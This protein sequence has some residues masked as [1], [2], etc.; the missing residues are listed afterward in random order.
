M[1]EAGLGTSGGRSTIGRREPLDPGLRGAVLH[2]GL[3]A[4]ENPTEGAG[5]GCHR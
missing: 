3:T 1:K 4:T 2:A 5:Y